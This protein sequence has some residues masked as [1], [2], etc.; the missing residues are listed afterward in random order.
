MLDTPGL[1]TLTHLEAPLVDPRWAPMVLPVLGVVSVALFV[2]L[3]AGGRRPPRTLGWSRRLHVWWRRQEV[4]G[5]GGFGG[6]FDDWLVLAVAAV[7]CNAGRRQEWSQTPPLVIHPGRWSHMEGWSQ[8][9]GVSGLT[10]FPVLF[11]RHTEALAVWLV[12]FRGSSCLRF[13]RTLLSHWC[14][15]ETLNRWRKASNHTSDRTGSV[16]KPLFNSMGLIRSN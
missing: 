14:C 2:V 12:F 16:F 10:C 7:G 4:F 8:K 6:A 5:G 3:M 15:K 9:G 13:F 11:G 1:K